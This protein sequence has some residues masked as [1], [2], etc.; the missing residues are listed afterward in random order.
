MLLRGESSDVLSA[1]IADRMKR[2]APALQVVV[3][4]GVGHAPTLAEPEALAA[5][6][7]FLNRVP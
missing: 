7:A 3:V 4:P 6:R 1:Q 2:K 5:I